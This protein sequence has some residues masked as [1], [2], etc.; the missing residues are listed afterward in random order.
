MLPPYNG[1]TQTVISGRCAGDSPAP[2][3]M[4]LVLVLINSA[5]LCPDFPH[6]TD[7]RKRK[8]TNSKTHSLSTT[9]VRLTQKLLVTLTWATLVTLT[10]LFSST[11]FIRHG[12]PEGLSPPGNCQYL[13]MRVLSGLGRGTACIAGVSWSI[14]LCWESTSSC[15]LFNYQGRQWQIYFDV[16]LYCI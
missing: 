15:D 16:Q 12:S 4:S 13:G 14:F 1:V 9:T 10:C 5:R 11:R 3:G 8:L 6:F 2:C 7:F